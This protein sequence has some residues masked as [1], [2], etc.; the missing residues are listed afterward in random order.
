M[1]PEIARQHAATPEDIDAAFSAAPPTVAAIQPDQEFAR[2]MGRAVSVPVIDGRFRPD[3]L[4]GYQRLARMYLAGGMVPSSLLVPGD[5]RATLARVTIALET[6]ACLGLT[7]AQSL[8]SIMVVN[9]RACLW[10]DGIAAK[11]LS[12]GSLAGYSITWNGSGDELTCAVSAL[13]LVRLAD[14]TYARIPFA[15]SFGVAEA[16]TAG[17]WGKGGPWRSYPRRMLFCRARAMCLRDGWA[18][19]LIGLPLADE[20]ADLDDAAASEVARRIAAS[21]GDAVVGGAKDPTP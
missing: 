6:G 9:G 12:S 18:D 17:L 19:V 10:G 8:A 3:S 14:G 1:P 15:G 11:V 7:A 13:R 4:D 5:D 21:G 20:L 16:R 2:M